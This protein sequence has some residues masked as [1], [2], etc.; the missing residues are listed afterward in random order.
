MIKFNSIS[1]AASLAVDFREEV[2]DLR[3]MIDTMPD[4]GGEALDECIR[5]YRSC[6]SSS[7]WKN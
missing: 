2:D 1:F 5:L 7:A 4:D 6:L 3:S